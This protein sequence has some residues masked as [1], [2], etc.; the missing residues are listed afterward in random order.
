MVAAAKKSHFWL[1]V[2]LPLQA[3]VPLQAKRQQQT[4]KSHNMAAQGATALCA[5]TLVCVCVCVRLVCVL[6]IAHIQPYKCVLLL[7]LWCVCVCVFIVV[8]VVVCVY[9]WC[10]LSCG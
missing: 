10:G 2:S 3:W 9:L 5:V 6:Y 8:A 1:V 4:A 7:L